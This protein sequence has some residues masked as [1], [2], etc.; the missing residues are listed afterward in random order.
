VSQRFVVK[1]A[2]GAI[3][4]QVTPHQKQSLIVQLFAISMSGTQDRFG[5]HGER[6]TRVRTQKIF[7][8]FHSK[9]RTVAGAHFDDSVVAITRRS[10]GCIS[11]A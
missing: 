10:S 6:K 3:C 11:T 5:E 4:D 7:E 1:E 8:A 2:S 9:L